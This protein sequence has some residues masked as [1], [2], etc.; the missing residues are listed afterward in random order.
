[1]HGVLL[2]LESKGRGGVGVDQ[3]RPGH[4][5]GTYRARRAPGT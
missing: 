4:P 5:P 2:L 1:V 3:R